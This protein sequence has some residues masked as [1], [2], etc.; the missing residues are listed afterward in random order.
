[1]AF[2]DLASRNIMLPSSTLGALC[3]VELVHFVF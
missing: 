3:I 2:F 1:M